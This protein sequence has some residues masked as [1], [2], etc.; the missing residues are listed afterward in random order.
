MDCFAIPVAVLLASES[1]CGQP[2]PA[3]Q[4]SWPAQRICFNECPHAVHSVHPVHPVHFDSA[5]WPW[6]GQVI[7]NKALAHLAGTA[8]QTGNPQ[9]H[10][11][12]R[13]RGLW[14]SGYAPCPKPPDPLSP[15]RTN[16][17]QTGMGES[18]RR[19]RPLTPILLTPRPSRE[20]NARAS[21]R[22]KAFP[23]NPQNNIIQIV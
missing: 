17:R 3:V 8:A 21:L 11:S 13:D 5:L 19:G 6:T 10:P 20:H 22:G 23:E 12:R 15:S 16:Q 1:L 2:R 18:A 7:K 4:Q 9:C 14:P